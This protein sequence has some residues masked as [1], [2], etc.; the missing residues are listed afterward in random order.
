VWKPAYL[1]LLLLPGTSSQPALFDGSNLTS[2]ESYLIA[3]NVLKGSVL[4]IGLTSMY[5]NFYLS[6]SHTLKVRDLGPVLLTALR[7]L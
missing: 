6:A 7:P 1:F 5:F 4:T 2:L 3:P